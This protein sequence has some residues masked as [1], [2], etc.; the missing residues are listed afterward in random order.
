MGARFWG[1]TPGMGT[2]PD[3]SNSPR[4]SQ[5][6]TAFEQVSAPNTG[7]AGFVR[8]VR[9]MVSGM[10]V[11][12]GTT[13]FGAVRKLTGM[14]MLAGVL[15]AMLVL[16]FV[17]GAGVSV[18]DSADWLLTEPVDLGDLGTPQRSQIFAADGSLIATFYRQNR[19]DIKLKD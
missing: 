11:D 14:G 8:S 2:I 12:G 15:A 6:R 1:M 18:R 4:N 9:S 3:P 16:P 19:V 10:D 13:K 7:L 5:Y 17:C